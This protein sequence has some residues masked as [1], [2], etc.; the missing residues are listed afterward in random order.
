MALRM[1]LRSPFLEE[2]RHHH[3]Q[4]GKQR[5]DARGRTD[6][7]PLVRLRLGR[8]GR[9][10]APAGGRGGGGGGGVGVALAPVHAPLA[11]EPRHDA[12]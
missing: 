2:A 10:V 12:D 1:L 11:M 8:G 5:S 6:L 7:G 9:G 4:Q 3:W